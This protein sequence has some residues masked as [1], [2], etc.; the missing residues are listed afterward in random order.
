VLCAIHQA[1]ILHLFLGINMIPWLNSYYNEFDT[2]LSLLRN[3]AIRKI[4]LS[5]HAIATEISHCLCVVC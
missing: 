1:N 5:D 3:T 4:L 2:V